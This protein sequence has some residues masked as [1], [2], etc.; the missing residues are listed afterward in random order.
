MT[1]FIMFNSVSVIEKHTLVVAGRP[2]NKAAFLCTCLLRI[3]F[4]ELF[5]ENTY[6]H[7]PWNFTALGNSFVVSN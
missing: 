5:L 3:S 2:W 6:L 7:L 1:N 4:L